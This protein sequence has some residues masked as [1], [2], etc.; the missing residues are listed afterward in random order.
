MI[1]RAILGPVIDF[2][3]LRSILKAVEAFELNWEASSEVSKVMKTKLTQ[4]WLFDFA[5]LPEL[6][7]WISDD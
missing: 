4:N 7:I 1:C 2:I 3:C 5:D 6:K